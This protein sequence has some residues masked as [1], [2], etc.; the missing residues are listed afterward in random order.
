M[1]GKKSDGA[2]GKMCGF[3]TS[4]CHVL[5]RDAGRR[6]G[7]GLEFSDHEPAGR[8]S[9]LNLAVVRQPGYSPA[10]DRS[11]APVSA[12]PLCLFAAVAQLAERRFRKA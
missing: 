10:F 6:H 11:G 1:V 7:L 4:D 9:C 5:G 3:R 8:P 2:G 12:S